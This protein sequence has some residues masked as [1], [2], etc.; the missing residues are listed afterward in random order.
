VPLYWRPHPGS[1]AEL[2][3]LGQA[4]ERLQTLLPPGLVVVADSALGHHK[5][6]CAADR[7]GVRARRDGHPTIEV[8]DDLGSSASLISPGPQAL[9][10]GTSAPAANPMWAMRR[11][12]LVPRRGWR[13]RSPGNR[14]KSRSVVIHSLPDSIASAAR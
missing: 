4:L 13:H 11:T 8:T 7:A 10:S 1:R 5:N 14:A 9:S 12:Y 6:L 3:A 2:T